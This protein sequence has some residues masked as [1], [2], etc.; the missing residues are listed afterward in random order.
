[1][2]QSNQFG[3]SLGLAAV[4]AAL[5]FPA[6]HA[7]DVDREMRTRARQNYDVLVGDYY[8]GR[9]PYF[10]ST[11]TPEPAPVKVVEMAQA[12]PTPKPAGPCSVIDTGLVRMTKTM[13]AEASL[14]E[15]F[16]SE[17][18]AMAV[19][20]AANVVVTDTLPDGVTLVG[21]EPPAT[22]NGK[23][24]VW[25]LGN[26]DAG[27]SKTLKITLKPEKEGTLINCAT[28]KADPRVCAQT[29]VG[30]PQ[31]AISKTGHGRRRDLHRGPGD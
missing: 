5:S 7:Q 18:K 27:E 30:R 24:L 14:G 15:S 2:K 26:L 25:N 17:I 21:S 12:K 13:P 3:L 6:L 31:L 19:G 11:S 4:L 9:S 20:C 8:T 10:R 16:T 22:V 29:V 23:Q 1:M 28:I